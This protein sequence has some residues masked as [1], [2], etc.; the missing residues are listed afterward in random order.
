MRVTVD[1]RRRLTPALRAYAE[2]RLQRLERH[3]GR[4]HEVR[5]ILDGADDQ[6]PPCRAEVLLHLHNTTQ[7]ARVAAATPREAIDLIMDKAD[8]LVVREKERLAEHR[9]PVPRRDRGG[10]APGPEA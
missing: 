3:S 7:A 1:A 8:R 9:G 5:L 10:S 6:Q 4:V 2:E